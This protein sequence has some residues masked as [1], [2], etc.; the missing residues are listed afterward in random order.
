MALPGD[1]NTVLVAQ[2]LN[3]SIFSQLWLV[4]HGIFEDAELTAGNFLFSPLAVNVET[5]Q[6]VFMAVP[7]RIQIAFVS[8]KVD[9]ES[10]Q[11]SLHRTLGRICSELPHTPFL[12]VGFNMGWTLEA[13][14]DVKM[15]PLERKFFLAEENP[16]AKFFSDEK[17][18]FGCYLSKDFELG[19]LKLDI[20][21]V[22]LKDGSST[23]RMVFNFHLDLSGE[24]KI[25]QIKK[26][27]SCWATAFKTSCTLRETLGQGW[28]KDGA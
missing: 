21:P 16:L 5:P 14:N 9:G 10:C 24:D 12:A 25:A 4:R 13:R 28:S 22:V 8:D 23:I 27:L 17:S 15:A 26:F 7:E 20:K 6:L 3:P 2:N 1:F 19:R 11:Q 18:R